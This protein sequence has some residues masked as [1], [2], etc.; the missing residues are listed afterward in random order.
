MKKKEEAFISTSRN[1]IKEL[2][3]KSR[4]TKKELIFLNN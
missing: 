2:K 3:A 1:R 4:K